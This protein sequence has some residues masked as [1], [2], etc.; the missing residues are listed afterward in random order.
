VLER[1]LRKLGD[2]TRLVKLLSERSALAEDGEQRALLGMERA[3]LLEERLR[4]LPEARVVLA[5]IASSGSALAGEAERRLRLMLE[6]SQDWAGLAK[7]FE[8]SLG[9]GDAQAD[10]AAH[11]QLA[12][13]ARDRM[14]DTPRAIA[15][16]ESALALT[17][18][19]LALHRL[20]QSA[21]ERADGAELCAAYER[22]LALGGIDDAR[23]RLLHGRCAELHE[24]ANDLARAETHHEALV[25]DGVATGR[26]MQFLAERYEQSGRLPQLAAL[27]RRRIDQLASDPASAA[28]VRLQLAQLEAGPLCEL[29]AALE[30]LA[31]AA[32]SDATLAIVSEPYARLLERAGRGEALVALA[33]RAAGAAQSASERSAWNTRLGDAL[34]E[35]GDLEAAAD[36]FRRALTDRPSDADLQSALRDLYRRQGRSEP[37]ARLLEAELARTTGPL[38]IPLRLELGEL[39]AG[40]LNDPAGALIHYRRALELE[41]KN[42]DTLAR[43]IAVAERANAHDVCAELLGRAAGIAGDPQRRA[44]LLT[45]RAALLAGPLARVDDAIASYEAALALAPDAPDTVAALRGIF[46]DRSEWPRALACFEREL[47]AT[48]TDAAAARISIIEEAVRFAS[49][50]LGG[51]ASL[52]WLERLRAA[53]PGDVGPIARI[54][55]AH[56]NAGRAESLL[57]A[58]EAEL[59]LAPEP[60]RR[61]ELSLEAAQLLCERMHAPARAAALLEAARS[62]A[63]ADGAVLAMLDALYVVLDR[64][65]DRLGVLKAR[66][67]LASHDVRLGLR[68]AASAV[69]RTLGERS[70]SDAQLW[71]ALAECG[72]ASRERSDLLRALSEDLAE[73]PDLA[74]RASEAEL[75]SLDRS[76]LVFA[77]RRRAVRQALAERYAASLAADDAAI[78]H[79]CALLDDELPASDASLAGP[80]E[81]ASTLLLDLYRRGGEPVQLARRLGEHLK[82]FPAR[83]PE[84]W[85][86]LARLRLEVLHQPGLAAEAFEAALARDDHS[87]PALRGLRGACELLGRWADVASTLERELA[88]R[89]DAT[90]GERA[91]LLRRI[92]EIRWK[93]LDETTKASRAY[94]SALEADPADL[95]ALRAL[96][97]LFE[98]MEDWRGALDLYESEISVLASAEPERRRACWL[99]AAEIAHRSTRELPRALRCYDA[100]AEL[101]PLETPR[102]AGLADVLDRLGERERFVATFAAWIDAPDSHALA[103][104]ELRLA[105]AYEELQRYDGALAR[106]ERAAKRAPSLTAA[107]DR[108]A[109][110]RERLGMGDEA[111]DALARAA[112]LV[113]GGEAAQRRVRAADLLAQSAAP[114]QRMAL[115][116]DATRDDPVSAEAFARL[117]LAA[118]A[119]GDLARAESAAERASALHAQGAA[120]EGAL[121]RDAALAG[122]RAA[123][124]LDRLTPAARLLSEVLAIEPNHAEALAQHGR[125][126]LRIGD[127]EGARRSLTRALEHSQAAGDRAPLLALLGNAEAAARAS[128]AALAH[129]REAL[130]L[131]PA[132]ADAHAGLVQVLL[133]EQ[134]D[135]EAIAALLAWAHC[136][137]APRDRAR[138]LLQAAELEL[139]RPQREGAAE[140]LLREATRADAALAEAWAL[141][142]ELLA[143]GARWSEVLDAA[144]AGALETNEPLLRSRLAAL[145]G[146]ALEQRGDVRAAA[147]AFAEAARTSPRASEA[148]LSS[149]RLYRGLGDWAAAADVLRKFAAG[150]PEDARGPRATALHQLGRLLAGP[151]EDVDGAIA[152]YR[153]ATSLGGDNREAREA[154]ADLLLHRQAHWDEAIAHHRELLAQ[155]PAR[156]A[157][158]RGLLRIARGRGNASASAH[159]L[160]L[161]RALGVATAEESR[162]APTRGPLALAA[163]PAL[164]DARFELARRLALEAKDDL[165]EALGGAH[166][167]ASPHAGDARA[168][169]RGALTAVEGELSAPALVPLTTAELAS[170][171]Q[172]VADLG[173]EVETVSAQS[174]LVNTLS[175]ALGWRAKKRI[176]RVLE[177]RSGD[178][179]A[180]IDFAAWRSA[181][182]GLAGAVLVDRGEVSLRDAFVAWIQSDDP[183]ASRTLPPE[184]DLRARV[185]AHAE[186]RELLRLAVNAWLAGL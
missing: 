147:D 52:P 69:A 46:E 110:L 122:A 15:H 51:E 21:L 99:R 181:L 163:K 182:R 172:L 157:S 24:R 42:A 116:E 88:M 113:G 179:L 104:D 171:L 95:S 41:P 138:R 107:W 73:R 87:L 5:E 80:R 50:M 142:A 135:A 173:S 111:A 137:G 36:A 132:Q 26:S 38:E 66:I 23:R 10:A 98:A 176:R 12:L 108:I 55:Q 126:L 139:N 91:A 34:R 70:E 123:L 120:L 32:A 68:T 112:A 168:R 141:L 65:R 180:A 29:D 140:L 109:A 167:A 28:T 82:A 184:V 67:G 153:D 44:R 17:P 8:I 54:A 14:H 160:S 75:A 22:E 177:A 170:T 101:A 30:T 59:E 121:R 20:L 149:A 152:A 118:G 53:K 100:A 92:G 129:Y 134:R 33:R 47:A 16:L 49:E 164:A 74:A 39:L 162:E 58:L 85:L 115:L 62:A 25:A 61:A 156:L 90:P 83:R 56:R 3:L 106:A 78:A 186:A 169:F 146:R 143:K 35:G 125:T 6:N 161:L 174:S 43:A 27:L 155:D 103:D 9:S 144:S 102:L 40:A 175:T 165:A 131:D 124:A 81:R 71:A 154:L 63:P 64:P 48:P 79:L 159:G 4:A 97:Q 145:R 128:D 117:A 158:L 119:S 7:R 1:A 86:E 19:D 151:L 72:P 84:P 148:A 183:D 89:A 96:Q 166:S 45:R 11:K 13:I 57:R 114:E 105:T 185:A 77:E 150:A 127:V 2:D 133:R 94:A 60:R 37:L 93:R 31:P 76:N 178:E 18:S 136:A 130:S